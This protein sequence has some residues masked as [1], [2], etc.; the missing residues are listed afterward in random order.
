MRKQLKVVAARS[1]WVGLASLAFWVAI[2]LLANPMSALGYGNYAVQVN[3][4][5]FFLR[6]SNTEGLPNYNPFAYGEAGDIPVA[7]DWNGDGTD[8]IGVYR[9]SNRTFYLRNGNFGGSADIAVDFGNN[10]DLPIV[11][12]WNNDGTD[13]IGVYRPSNRTFYLRNSNSNGAADIAVDWGNPSDLPIVGDWNNDGTDTIGVY[14]PS[15]HKFYLRNSNTEGSADLV[16][17]YGASGDVPIVGDWN[18]DGID[19]VGVFRH[20]SDTNWHLRNNNLPSGDTEFEFRFGEMGTPQPVTGDWNGDGKTTIGFYLPPMAD[21]WDH[22]ALTYGFLNGTNDIAG[23]GERQAVREVLEIWSKATT[24]T[25]Y[26]TTPQAAELKFG[27][28]APWSNSEWPFS[29]AGNLDWVHSRFPI[30]GTIEF[31]DGETWTTSTR[32]GTAPPI[33]LM[34]V[35]AHAIGHVLGL[36][37]SE[38]AGVMYYK[39]TG[40]SRV[41]SSGEKNQV[42]A[43]YGAHPAKRRYFLRYSRSAGTPDAIFEGDGGFNGYNRVGRAFSGDW[44]GDGTDTLGIYFPDIA[45]FTLYENNSSESKYTSVILRVNNQIPSDSWQWYPVAGDWNNDGKDT[46][47]YFNQHNYKFH[48]FAENSESSSRNLFEFGDHED[49]PVAGDWNGDGIDSVGVYRPSTGVFY[50]KDTNN[51]SPQDYAFAYGNFGDRPV[52]G[53]WDENGRDSVGVYR[54]ENGVWYLDNELPA[55]QPISYVF[56]YGNVGY[57]MSLVGDWNGSGT[58]DPA[59]AQEP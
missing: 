34:T 41:L 2:L 36:G 55:N 31:N 9:P 33:D 52:A 32:S 57:L 51:G 8:T 16:F 37:D 7:G 22:T 11:G 25:F 56:P 35:A 47:G 44:N 42:A 45:L 50:L 49:L 27:W 10:G 12:D 46:I 15:E 6:N 53:D 38:S 59:F 26:E 29:P 48:L 40:S 28:E 30:D 18:G 54:P 3:A 20:G 4:P 1:S 39:Y 13:T 23:E 5:R 43:R 19:T 24:L 58:D 14:R 17:T 21:R